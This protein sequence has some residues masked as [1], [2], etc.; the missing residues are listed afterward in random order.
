[1]TRSRLPHGAAVA[2]WRENL[3]DLDVVV[4]D[5]RQ[6]VEAALAEWR[7]AVRERDRAAAHLAHLVEW[8]ARAAA[9]GREARAS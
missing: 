4:E 7:D 6:R 9:T 5:A 8:A 3:I 1:M 2:R